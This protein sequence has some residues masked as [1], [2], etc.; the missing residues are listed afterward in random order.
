M[1]NQHAI[2][3]KIVLQGTL[4]SI[5]PFLVASGADEQADTEVIKLPDGQP[6]VPGSSFAG[7]LKRL[8]EDRQSAAYQYLWGT[9]NP[10]GKKAG[11]I[12]QSHIVIDNLIP[13]D[14]NSSKLKI[15]IRDSVKIDPKT[16]IAETGSKY[17]YEIVEPGCKF[18]FRIEVTIRNGNKDLKEGIEKVLG[19]IVYQLKTGIRLGANTNTGFGLFKAKDKLACVEF[20]FSSSKS[21]AAAMWFKYLESNVLPEEWSILERIEKS[22]E[23]KVNASFILDVCFRLKSA[24]ITATYGVDATQPDKTQLK[25]N[26]KFVLSGKSIRGAVRHRCRKILNTLE[27][28]DSEGLLYTLFGNVETKDGKDVN[29]IKG[30][31]II[32]ETILDKAVV[33][34]EQPRIRINRFLG[35]A[36]DNALFSSEAVWRKGVGDFAIRFEV[37]NPEKKEIGLLLLILKDLWTGDLAIGGEKNIGRGVLQG[38]K[39]TINIGDR[40][41][42]LNSDSKLPKEAVDFLE[43]HV[44]ALTTQDKIA[45]S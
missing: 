14:I 35:S 9:S 41:I 32:D 36:A 19:T 24:L 1:V 16:G 23:H 26:D 21:N 44:Q 34:M 28:A 38:V 12:Y 40:E 25:A 37:S 27:V 39:A 31:L 42:H 45:A 6:F 29:P 20:D 11:D 5:S 43:E 30:K 2:Y 22:V 7:V 13:V 4:L 17:D 10:K 18:S 3:S 8:C 33:A 15:S